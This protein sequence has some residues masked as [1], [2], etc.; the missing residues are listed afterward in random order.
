MV[1]LESQGLVDG[2]ITEDSDLLVFGAR[3]V[4]FKFDTSGSVMAISRTD[5]G[6]IH[7][8]TVSLVGWSDVQ[9]REMAVLSG[10]DYLP[11]IQGIGL[12]T[13]AKLLRKHKTVEKVLQHL[14]LE[15]AK[16]IPKGYLDNLR[17]AELAFQYQRVYD[18][19]SQRLVHLGEPP[20]KFEWDD[21]KN[22]YVGM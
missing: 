19:R 7:S 20:S 15:G 4:L 21:S 22:S 12:I 14:R 2:I 1:Y 5:F 6:Q 13:A 8:S 17:T 10:C 16:R 11:S 9:F 18:P 3:L